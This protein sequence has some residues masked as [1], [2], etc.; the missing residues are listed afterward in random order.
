MHGI[1]WYD[2]KGN[3]SVLT[4]DEEI[5]DVVMQ[6]SEGEDQFSPPMCVADVWSEAGENLIHNVRELV[7]YRNAQ[8]AFFQQS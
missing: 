4:N 5:A 8:K 2:G 1:E 3:I 6:W 7:E